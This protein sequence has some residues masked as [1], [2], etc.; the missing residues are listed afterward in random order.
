MKKVVCLS[1]ALACLM[2]A[3]PAAAEKTGYVNDRVL[4]QKST[5]LQGLQMQRERIAAVLKSDVENE[6]RKIFEKKQKLEEESAKMSRTDLAKRLDEIDKEE[7]DLKARAQ[8]AA[9]ELQKNFLDA[10]VSYKE[11][12]IQPVIKTLAD[13]NDFDAVLDASNAFYIEKGLDV[14]DEAVARVNKKMPKLDLKK[15]TLAK[16]KKSK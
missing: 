5:A 9:V 8:A 4:A 6:A 10:V 16:S 1:I 7:Q 13:E 15:V 11:K 12:A 3:N 2:T 14:T